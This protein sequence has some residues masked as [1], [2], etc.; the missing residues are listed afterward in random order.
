MYKEE[1][2]L[3]PFAT[4]QTHT[5]QSPT[6]THVDAPHTLYPG[7]NVGS[8][9]QYF[10]SITHD[11][12]STKFSRIVLIPTLVFVAGVRTESVVAMDN[13]VIGGMRAGERVGC[14]RMV[15]GRRRRVE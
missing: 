5:T 4:Y 11:R 13:R 12:T 14:V 8:I 1:T 10:D 7:S 6:N 9:I 2:I 3:L 15:R